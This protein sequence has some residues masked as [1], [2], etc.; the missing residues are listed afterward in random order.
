MPLDFAHADLIERVLAALPDDV[1]VARAM[2]AL[3]D[4]YVALGL[5]LSCGLVEIA[6]IRRLAR[7]THSELRN[8]LQT[9]EGDGEGGAAGEDA[10]DAQGRTRRQD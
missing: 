8:E 1:S 9:L 7:E 4:A 3:E 6:A 10:S 2:L 5:G